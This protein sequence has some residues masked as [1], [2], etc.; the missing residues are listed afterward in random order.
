MVR[1]LAAALAPPFREQN[2]L[3]LAALFA[4]LWREQRLDA[5]EAV[6]LHRALG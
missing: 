6:T 4:P 2:A 1:H 5:P 3:L